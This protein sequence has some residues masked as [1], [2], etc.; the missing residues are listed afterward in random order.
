VTG[1]WRR[2][3][4]EKLVLFAKNSWNDRVNEAEMSRAC[5]TNESEEKCVMVIGGRV[6]RKETTRKIK[7]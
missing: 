3:H 1:S 5:S 6:R 4:N 2:L 7:I